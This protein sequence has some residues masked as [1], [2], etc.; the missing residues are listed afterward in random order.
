MTPGFLLLVLLVLA[1]YRL[2]HLLA[3]DG[4]PLVAGPRDRIEDRI[5]ASHGSAWADGIT[6]AWCLGTWCALAVV[7]VVWT[8][9]P[10]LPLPALWFGA[11]A[12][13]VGVLGEVV[14]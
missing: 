4:L 14:G 10:S 11:T 7:A 3:L 6:C 9:L 8:L 13:G 12:A 5:E 1:A 2:W